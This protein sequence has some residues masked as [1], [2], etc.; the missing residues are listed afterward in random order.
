MRRDDSLA[1]RKTIRLTDSTLRDRDFA[2]Y[3]ADSALRTAQIDAACIRSGLARR[4]AREVT[5]IQYLVDKMVRSG[6]G[7]SLLPP[8]ALRP[9]ADVVVGIPV[10]PAIRRDICAVT[11]RGRSPIGA[12]QALLD[13]LGAEWINLVHR[14]LAGSACSAN[15]DRAEHPPVRLAGVEQ[16]PDPVVLE[17]A[18][19]EADALDPFDQVVEGFGGTVGTRA[20]WKLAILSNQWRIVRPRRWISGG[21]AF[22]RQ[23]A[24]RSL[25]IALASSGSLVR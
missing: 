11:A 8:M 13:L 18:E 19:A 10:T 24:W 1:N 16:G 9:V 20:R 15:D 6:A 23:C 17:V 21:M 14:I 22:F 4:V 25:S 3:R 12:A 2:E 5:T 7:L